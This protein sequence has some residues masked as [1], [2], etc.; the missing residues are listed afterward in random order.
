MDVQVTIIRTQG[1]RGEGCGK[2]PDVTQGI[3]GRK[4]ADAEARLFVV[5]MA[6]VPCRPQV[7]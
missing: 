3:R 7:S 1:S 4:A 2:D 5:A 6:P